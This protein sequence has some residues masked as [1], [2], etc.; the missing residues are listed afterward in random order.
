M[1]RALFVILVLV[2]LLSVVTACGATEQPA[3]EPTAAAVS[4]AQPAEMVSRPSSSQSWLALMM[5]PKS[6]IPQL[7]PSRP[8]V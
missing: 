1:K 3:A 2:T 4:G 8:M 5:A 7:G 6:S